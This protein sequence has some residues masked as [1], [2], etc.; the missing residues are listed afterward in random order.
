ME[1]ILFAEQRIVVTM[2]TMGHAERWCPVVPRNTLD[3]QHMVSL[4]HIQGSGNPY[5]ASKDNLLIGVESILVN[6]ADARRVGLLGLSSQRLGSVVLQ[7]RSGP[8]A[9]SFASFQ[10]LAGPSP[11]NTSLNDE[12]A[13]GRDGKQTASKTSWTGAQSQG[14]S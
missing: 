2:P 10:S 11:A 13:R 3:V 14:R 5:D 12:Y 9:R 8:I 7:G 6:L 4:R 1:D